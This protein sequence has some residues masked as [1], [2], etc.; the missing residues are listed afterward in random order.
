MQRSHVPRVSRAACRAWLG[1]RQARA[2]AARMALTAWSVRSL[3][4]PVWSSLPPWQPRQVSIVIASGQ[5][6]MAAAIRCA[7]LRSAPE[8][9]GIRLVSLPRPGPPVR[10]SAAGP[11]GHRRCVPPR[12]QPR[13]R[14]PGSTTGPSRQV[15]SSGTRSSG[16]EARAASWLLTEPRPGHDQLPVP[17]VPAT[18][19]W[20]PSDSSSK[21]G[22]GRPGEQWWHDVQ[23]SIPLPGQGDPTGQGAVASP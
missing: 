11:A 16:H 23:P 14:G 17:R 2:P 13:G 12:Q 15:P 6:A 1:I 19:I 21:A 8:T 10:C 20:A 4:T 9:P 5:G 3:G 22:C 7:M 18:S